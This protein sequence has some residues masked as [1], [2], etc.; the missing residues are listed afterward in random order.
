MVTSV[1]NTT[2]ST[3]DVWPSDPAERVRKLGALIETSADELERSQRIPL[4]LLEQLHDSRLLRLLL[5]TSVGG[6]QVEPDLYFE[7]IEALGRYDGSVAWNAFVANRSAL[8]A[9]C[10]PEPAALEIFSDPRTVVA[11]GPPTPTRAVAVEGGFRASGTWGFAS[12]C[13]Q[14]NWM[15]VHCLVTEPDGSVRLSDADR[16][17]VMSLLFPATSARILDDW[18]PIGLRGTGSCSYT[19]DD[20]FIPEGFSGTREL[21]EAHRDEAPLYAFTQ[22]GLYAVGVAGVA[23]GLADRMLEEFIDLAKSKS[24]R[25]IGRLAD[26]EQVQHEVAVS[27]AQLK[28]S[29]TWLLETIR[30]IYRRAPCVGAIDIDDRARLRLACSHA[31]QMAVEVGD[32]VYRAAGVSAIFPG[33]PFERRFRDLHTL[34]QQ[35]QSRLAHFQSVGDVLLGNEPPIFY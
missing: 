5:P 26:K 14:A 4:P 31:I 12:G 19:V 15:G 25:G 34:S 29:R 7:A 10:I 8:I 35:I 20:I 13:R 32:K 16:P 6:E 17:I 28:S 18:T 9:P 30:D 27:F 33:S 24:P 11:W 23:H 21:P 1:H 2:P 3:D 22:Q